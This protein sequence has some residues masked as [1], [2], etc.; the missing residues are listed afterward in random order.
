MDHGF[1]MLFRLCLS[2]TRMHRR[3]RLR[4]R[5]VGSFFSHSCLP[6]S[7][8]PRA[9]TRS[10]STAPI[11]SPPETSWSSCTPTS[12]SRARRT[13][14][15]GVYPTNHQE[16]ETIELT[17]GLNDWSEVG[18]Y[19]FTSEQDGHGVQWVGDHIRPARARARFLALAGRRRALHRDRLPARRLLAR[20]LDVGDAPHRRQ[21]PRPLVLRRQPGAGAHLAWP[22]CG[23]GHRLRARRQNR[24]RLH[25]G[26]QRGLRVLRRLRQHHRRPTR[27]TIS[28][29]RSSPSPISTSR[30]NGRST[31]ASASAPPQPPTTSSSK[32]ILGRR[33]DWGRHSPVD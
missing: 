10:R 14:I 31:S 11:P 21:D 33:F 30:P 4:S 17:E 1:M 24:L 20:H 28:S 12:P 2:S 3:V 9:T 5:C 16:H 19:I 25:Q 13:L 22:R 7:L 8:A 26:S 29:S 32:R 23:T 27:C 15:D 18:F 6:P